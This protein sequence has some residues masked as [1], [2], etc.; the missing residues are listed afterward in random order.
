MPFISF[1]CLISVA[2]TSD[3]MLNRSGESGNPCLVP[4]LSGKALSFCPLSMMLAVGLSYLAFIMLRNAAFIPTLLTV[5]YQKWV[6]YLI[7]CF[8]HIYWYD[9][10]IFSLLLLMWC[11]MFIDLGILYHPCIPGMNPTW[12]WYIIFLMYC[13][14]WFANI[15]LRILASLFISNMGLKFSFFVL[16]WDLDDAGFIKRVWESSISLDFFE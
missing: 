5:F 3:T 16:F 4:D 8:F 13:W 7:K 15:S 14:M 2:R 1:S 6:L 11:I 9:H 12:S 10:V